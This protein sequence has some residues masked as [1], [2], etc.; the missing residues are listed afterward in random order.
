MGPSADSFFLREL[1]TVAVEKKWGEKED[2]IIARVTKDQ[3]EL[4]NAEATLACLAGIRSLYSVNVSCCGIGYG[5]MLVLDE[6]K[7]QFDEDGVHV[8]R[9]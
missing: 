6:D 7:A 2:F 3:E 5:E 1:R 9:N 4:R 8:P